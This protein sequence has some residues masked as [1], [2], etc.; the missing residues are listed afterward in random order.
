MEEEVDDPMEIEDTLPAAPIIERKS[1]EF[2]LP[3]AIS[4]NSDTLGQAGLTKSSEEDDDDDEPTKDQSVSEPTSVDD[5]TVKDII[6]LVEKPHSSRCLNSACEGMN[7]EFILAPDFCLSYYRVKRSKSYKEEI[8]GDCYSKSLE[9]YDKLST[10]L[11]SG[12]LILSID[13]PIINETLQ[14]EDSDEE[15]EEK[16]EEMEYIDEEN[17]DFIKK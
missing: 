13:Y 14:I 2:S 3:S 1:D 7:S 9:D 15:D 10:V 8:C 17:F 16:E 12:N 11:K 4:Y 6:D 5:P